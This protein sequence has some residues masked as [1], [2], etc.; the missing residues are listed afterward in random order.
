LVSLGFAGHLRPTRPRLSHLRV[1]LHQLGL[2]RQETE[3]L[4]RQEK[5]HG[6]GPPAPGANGPDGDPVRLGSATLQRVGQRLAAFADEVTRILRRGEDEGGQQAADR[7]RALANRL[8]NWSRMLLTLLPRFWPARAV[9]E[10]FGPGQAGLAA[11]PAGRDAAAAPTADAGGEAR[12]P[13]G[14]PVAPP[15]PFARWVELAEDVVATQAVIYVSQFFVQLRNLA[16]S[17]LVCSVLLLLAVTSYPFEPQRLI[18]YAMLTLIGAALAGTLYVLFSANRNELL[19][20]ITGTT[21]NHFTLDSGFISSVFTYIV[22]A[23]LIVALQL[24]G[25]F[26]FMLEPVLRVLK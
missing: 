6:A 23:V 16:V 13:E 17:M 12:S 20:R 3:R 24:S 25:T 9:D 8:S 7:S 18:V 26:R 22:P 4:L 19:S 11:R 2:L 5:Q 14:R 21:P 15:G 1:P 10:A